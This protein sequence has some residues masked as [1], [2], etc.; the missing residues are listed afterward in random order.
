MSQSIAKQDLV[1]K[2]AEKRVNSLLSD[3]AAHLATSEELS[4]E[5]V[6]DLRV[7]V[8][9][10]RALLQL[11]RPCCNKQVIKQIDHDIKA[12][13][14]AFSGQRDMVVQ[15]QLLSK[16]M[17]EINQQSQHDFA[18]LRAYFLRVMTQEKI[19]SPEL[20]VDLAFKRALKK[21]HK[22]LTI[23]K[24]KIVDSGLRYTHDQC[25][26]RA[27]RAIA[28]GQDALYHAARKWIKYYLYQLKLLTKKQVDPELELAIKQ[29]DAMGEL[30]GE[31]HDQCVLEH[32][33]KGLISSEEKPSE[34]AN[35][36]DEVLEAIIHSI[37]H[38]L[39]S[40]KQHYKQQFWS[41]FNHFFLHTMP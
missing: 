30:L 36:D 32:T 22:H 39:A 19:E 7:C 35:L 5:L 28:T 11:Y 23:N 16:A 10:L 4:D 14:N 21:W 2:L 6:H 38:W 40:K 26:K 13:A 20:M 29:L 8:K 25:Y 17:E 9:R 24:R 3:I 37:L 33:L 31:L 41:Q 12:I 1:Y 15:Y 34:I 18:P 27:H